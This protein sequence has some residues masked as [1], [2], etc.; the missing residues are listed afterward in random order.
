MLHRQVAGL[1]EVQDLLVAEG[2]PSAACELLARVRLDT[3]LVSA[4]GSEAPNQVLAAVH[5]LTATAIRPSAA[6]SARGTL[7][8]P[9]GLSGAA[10][11]KS[12][13]HGVA[14]GAAAS[15]N[16]D[17]LIV[18]VRPAAAPSRAP[19]Q[20]P[21][22]TRKA[23]ERALQHDPYNRRGKA[24]SYGYFACAVCVASWRLPRAAS[25]ASPDEVETGEGGPAPPKR[26]R[27]LGC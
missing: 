19:A 17:P 22:Q 5:T 2:R 8:E 9:T 11:A 21:S 13:G 25:A 3:C 20:A 4:Y 12:R 10:K 24:S 26:A 18:P 7:V 6:Q 1:T 14:A 23:S 15:A 16:H 27:L